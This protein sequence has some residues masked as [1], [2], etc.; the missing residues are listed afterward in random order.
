MCYAGLDPVSTNPPPMNI[1]SIFDDIAEPLVALMTIA[2]AD[3]RFPSRLLCCALTLP[4][5]SL[6][7]PFL[8]PALRYAKV[9]TGSPCFNVDQSILLSPA[10]DMLHLVPSSP[11]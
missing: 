8:D 5:P 6:P 10:P 4:P 11:H 9:I 1:R 2:K 7:L 3:K